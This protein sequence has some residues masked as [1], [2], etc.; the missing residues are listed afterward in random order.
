MDEPVDL[1]FKFLVEIE[2]GDSPSGEDVSNPI[3]V[4]VRKAEF[5]HLAKRA[6]V[7]DLSWDE[8]FSKASQHEQASDSRSTHDALFASEF[9]FQS[10]Y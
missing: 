6:G 9:G 1:Q 8:P 5:N 3:E 10:N 4:F 2:G 7:R